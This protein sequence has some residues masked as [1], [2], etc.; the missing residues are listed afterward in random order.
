MQN[1]LCV[2]TPCE[3]GY[4]DY[5]SFQVPDEAFPDIQN[6]IGIAKGFKQNSNNQTNDYTSL[7]AVFLSVPNGYHCVDL[8]LYKVNTHS[9]LHHCLILFY[10]LFP[11]CHLVVSVSL[12]LSCPV[13]LILKQDKELVLLMNETSENSEGS[14]EACMMVVQTGDLPFISISRTRCLNQWE[15]EDLKVMLILTILNF[16]PSEVI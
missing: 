4:T 9:L 6:C 1:E 14:G 11:P 2:D 3:S 5:I 10:F 7:E 12:S 15:L 13:T 8:S 16:S